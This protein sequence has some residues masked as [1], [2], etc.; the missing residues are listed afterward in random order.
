MPSETALAANLHLTDAFG[1]AKYR[2]AIPLMSNED[3]TRS[4]ALAGATETGY[5]PATE[6]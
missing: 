1:L 6:G 5:G 3:F 2:K 4:L